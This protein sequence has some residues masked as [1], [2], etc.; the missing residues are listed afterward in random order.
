MSIL[1]EIQQFFASLTRGA[2]PLASLPPEYP[3]YAIR[4]VDGFGVAIEWDQEKPVSEFFSSAHLMSARTLIGGEQKTLLA[5]I[6][7][8]EEYRNEFATVC[9]QFVDPGND[10]MDRSNL[11]RDPIGWWQKWKNLLG[12]TA[13]D[14][15]PY[16]VLAEMI[17]LKHVMSFDPT[18]RWTASESGTHDIESD[19]HSYEVKST[20]IRYGALLSISSQ[21]QLLNPKPLD[22][23][24]IR[25]EESPSGVSINDIAAELVSKGYDESLLEIQL[26]KAHFERGSSDRD[27]KFTILEKRLYAVDDGFPRITA[28]SFKGDTIPTA[29]VEIHYKVDLDGVPYANW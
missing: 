9:A 6:S 11:V 27:R 25:F 29:I 14:K 12:N 15:T 5:L 18:A 7:N 24:F 2:A 22:L 10:G 8:R 4:A 19:N 3:A 21:F 26:T 23:F 1:Q 28:Q 17:V 20:I 13:L 16:S